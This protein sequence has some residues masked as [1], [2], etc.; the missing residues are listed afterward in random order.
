MADTNATVLITGESG[1]GKE[2]IEQTIR[3]N[4]RQRREPF[5]AVNC[6]VIS[7]ALQESEFFGHVK[8]EFPGATERKIGKF[9]RANGGPIFFDEISE[10]SK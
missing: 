4:S 6:G 7:E 3:E 10:M 9:E 2:L 8:G 1:T 5:V